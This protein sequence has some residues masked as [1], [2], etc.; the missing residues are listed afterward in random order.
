MEEQAL[1]S[2]SFEL[3]SDLRG[4]YPDESNASIERKHKEL[5]HSDTLCRSMRNDLRGT[6][7]TLDE[8]EAEISIAKTRLEVL[9]ARMAELGGYLAYLASVK[10]AAT[11]ARVAA[12]DPDNWPATP[13]SP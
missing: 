13:S 4:M 1:E 3:L 8:V 5:L 9:T 11:A 6:V 12:S 2:R 7:D 10:S